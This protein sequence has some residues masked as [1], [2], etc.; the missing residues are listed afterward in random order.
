M[1]Q[2]PIR[3]VVRDDLRRNRVTV[4]FRLLLAIPHYVW[5]VLWTVVAIVTALVSWV[6]T[7]ARGQAPAPL[8]GFLARYVRY[9]THLHAY[10]LLTADPYP[11]FGG[12]PGYPIDVEIDPPA[13]QHR[14][15]TAV[16][17]LLALP[18][19]VLADALVGFGTG[20]SWRAQGG[21][22]AYR[23]SENGAAVAVAFLAWF[24]ILARGTMPRG[25]RDLQAYGLRF[26]AQTYGY[27]LLLTDRY[28]EPRPAEPPAA[29]PEA[30][31]PV[32]LVVT[33]DLRR[34]RLTV[35]FRI[36][37]ALPHLIWIA[38]W[39]AVLIPTLV[40]SWLLT[41]VLGRLPAPLHRFIAAYL[42]YQTHLAAFLYLVASPFPGFTGAPGYPADLELPAAPT[43]QKRA[44]TAFRLLLVIPAWLTAAGLGGAAVVAA[45]LGWFASLVTGRMPRGLRDLAAW[46][47]RYTGQADAYLFFLTERYPYSVPYEF[48]EPPPEEELAEQAVAA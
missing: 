38:L 11:F 21:G 37:L 18:A 14:G 43:P 3:L 33:D 34:S 26:A 35:F 24:A 6:A 10:L 47:I 48:A 9:V 41:L 17:I 28:P 40:V 39:L 27:L 13:P 5:V 23:L 20:S 46:S 29:A 32:R 19:L 2:H 7:L 22:R 1:S 4:F 15:K 42:R 12:A 31:H 44:R 45:I 16:R 36:L 8:H 25:F 30:E